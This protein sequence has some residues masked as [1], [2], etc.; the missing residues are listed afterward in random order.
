[1]RPDALHRGGS[2]LAYRR[3]METCARRTR[4]GGSFNGGLLQSNVGGVR[5]GDGVV[6]IIY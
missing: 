6:F 4:G 3:G 5:S 2:P 1:M